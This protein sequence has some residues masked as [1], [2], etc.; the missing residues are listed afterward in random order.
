MENETYHIERVKVESSQIES[1][2][3]DPEKSVLDV[4]FRGG[5]VYR[6]D[7]VPFELFD[8]LMKSESKGKFFGQSIKAHPVHFPFT[9]IRGTDREEAKKMASGVKNV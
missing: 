5:S 2:G 8:A 1:V 3:Y 6:Y 9:K 4:E 7:H